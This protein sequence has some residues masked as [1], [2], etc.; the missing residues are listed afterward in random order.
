[1]HQRK[2]L[3]ITKRTAQFCGTRSLLHASGIELVG[4]A[5]MRSA[6]R[7]IQHEAVKG[8]IVCLHSWSERERD[9]MVSELAVNHP[10]VAVI[11]RCPG[12]NGCD[13]KTG[14]PGTLSE[15]RQFASL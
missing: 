5:S 12:C 11:V 14:V 10:E 9:A 13:E 15:T 6:L 7:V 8:V 3:A 4:A 2:V 1:M